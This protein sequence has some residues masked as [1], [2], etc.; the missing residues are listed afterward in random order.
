[1][2][3]YATAHNREFQAWISYADVAPRNLSVVEKMVRRLGL[4]VVETGVRWAPFVAK[5]RENASETRS[6]DALTYLQPPP[7]SVGLGVLK[8]ISDSLVIAASS[9]ATTLLYQAIR[10][11]I[12]TRN[13]RRIK[14]RIGELELETTQLSQEEFLRLLSVVREIHNSD[15]IRTKLLE[16]GIQTEILGPNPFHPD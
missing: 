16:A 14:L 13:G 9:G 5:R 4:C 7:P 2:H 15:Q 11:W 12:D 8:F 6:E 10:G 1:M 3:K